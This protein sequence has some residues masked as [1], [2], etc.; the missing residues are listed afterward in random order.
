MKIPKNWKIL[1]FFKMAEILSL[2]FW[3]LNIIYVDLLKAFK[4]IHIN[5]QEKFIRENY[6]F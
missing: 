2:L 4:I 1:N 5:V 3:G 6:F